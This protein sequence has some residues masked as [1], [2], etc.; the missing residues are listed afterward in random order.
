[1]VFSLLLS[2]LE[3]DFGEG[4]GL[5][6]FV[7]LGDTEG[8]PFLFVEIEE[9]HGREVG[10]GGGGS[11][12]RFVLGNEEGMEGA[13]GVSDVTVEFDEPKADDAVEQ[14]FSEGLHVPRPSERVGLVHALTGEDVRHVHDA[15]RGCCHNDGGFS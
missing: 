4:I 1:M 2:L 14:C 11:F 15:R 6:D 12:R 3:H 9:G 7:D 10:C 8:T 13:F 5:E